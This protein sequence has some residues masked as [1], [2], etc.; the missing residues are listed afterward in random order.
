MLVLDSFE[1]W[2]GH[3]HVKVDSHSAVDSIVPPQIQPEKHLIFNHVEIGIGKLDYASRVA[4]PGFRI[5]SERPLAFQTLEV[6]T[7][8]THLVVHL[9]A[10]P[11]PMR[12]WVEVELVVASD[13]VIWVCIIIVVVG[14]LN[15]VVVEHQG[16]FFLTMEQDVS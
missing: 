2:L 9:V 7:L 16:V 13:A 11:T 1:L 5:D 15:A 6:I 12:Y 4:L 8:Y 3:G 14:S 10:F